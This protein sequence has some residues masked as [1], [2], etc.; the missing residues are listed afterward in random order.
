MKIA[1]M[2]IGIILITV[3]CATVQTDPLTSDERGGATKVLAKEQTNWPEIMKSQ[4]PGDSNSPV[5]AYLPANTK[6]TAPEIGLPPE[7]AA[8]SGKWRGWADRD[9]QGDV[10]LAVEM[11]TTEGAAI[12]YSYASNAVKPFA[13]RLQAKFV[14]N[15][16]QAD[17]SKDVR[18]FYRMRPDGDIEFMWLK[19][20]FW[21]IGV[22]SKEQ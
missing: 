12:I 8:W 9:R 16:L 7:K 21:V 19:G 2:V 15:E 5:S 17:L 20:K 22:L 1:T 4:L 14:G 13:R 11:V 6:I 10:R 3:G 18:V